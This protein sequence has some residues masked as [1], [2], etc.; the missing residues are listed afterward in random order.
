MKR[1]RIALAGFGV[2]AVPLL[3]GYLP[4][5]GC[6]ST[7]DDPN[8]SADAAPSDAGDVD[9]AS[10]ADIGGGGDAAD[11]SDVFDASDGGDADAGDGPRCTTDGW[12]YTKLPV[13][14]AGVMTL[15]DVWANH[16]EAWA[17]T[18]EGLV[19]HWKNDAWSIAF[20]ASAGLTGVLRDHEGTVWVI[21]KA[22][23][24]FRHVAGT[25]DTE[26]APVP[27]GMTADL[28]GICEGPIDGSSPQNLWLAGQY[29][30]LMQWTGA[31]QGSPVWSFTPL[32]PIE[33]RS[34]WC[35]QGNVW[36]V[37]LDMTNN[38]SALYF[39]SGGVW[40]KLSGLPTTQFGRPFTSVWGSSA[41]DIWM[42]DIKKIVH[43]PGGDPPAWTS[44]DVGDWHYTSPTDWDFWGTDPSDV[45]L[46]G[47]RGRIYHYDGTKL[48]LSSTSLNGV[49]MT[50]NLHGIS[51]ASADD[52]WVV[53]D[54]IALHRKAKN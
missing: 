34:M 6:A 29:T 14:D 22:G 40:T 31:V 41:S 21:G 25:P 32:G 36:A 28:V 16:D 47:R 49:V 18:N 19:L 54:D 3:A 17:V 2:L 11:A 1:H 50:N 37:G 7:E 43:G 35:S 44:Y 33:I 23:T 4:L 46:V 26:W 10:D 42:A 48:E 38:G 12:C 51:G 27:A 5:A 39:G 8:G 13:T 9:R 30:V 45:W 20:T 15:T 53:G 52:L 24:L